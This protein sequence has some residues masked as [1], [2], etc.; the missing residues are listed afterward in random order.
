MT[1]FVVAL[2]FVALAFGYVQFVRGDSARSDPADGLTLYLEGVI[3][4]LAVLQISGSGAMG[5]GGAILIGVVMAV[6]VG[7]ATVL[8]RNSLIQGTIEMIFSV[9]ALIALIPALGIAF[10]DL[11]CG[12][13]INRSAFVAAMVVFTISFAGAALFAI[14]SARTWSA[15]LHIGMGWFGFVELLLFWSLPAAW[16]FTGQ[17]LAPT[18]AAIIAATL[19]GALVAFRPRIAFA[20][21][22][23]LIAIGAL[24]PFVTSVP[25][26]ADDSLGGTAV[27]LAMLAYAIVGYV[28]SSFR[29]KRARRG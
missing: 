29:L 6:A 17:S 10:G 22:G 5:S 2:L 1:G 26:C 8:A 28:I 23:L 12:H 11:S 24:I 14:F 20:V 13:V 4:T 18:A 3:A 27:P 9:I 25:T 16:Q 15:V 21:I 19:S 7:I